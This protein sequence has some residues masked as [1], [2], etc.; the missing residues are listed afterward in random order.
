[1]TV[2]VLFEEVF[3][4]RGWAI[5]DADHPDILHGL[6]KQILDTVRDISGGKNTAGEMDSLRLSM[7]NI[8]EDEINTI[9]L[10]PY[11]GASELL[12]QAFPSAVRNLSG[13]EIFL[14]RRAHM[15]LNLP[16]QPGGRKSDR[17]LPSLAHFDSM[18]GISP[19]TLSLWM[20]LHDLDDD[21]GV[22]IIDQEASMEILN[23]E[24]KEGRVLGGDVLAMTA[25]GMEKRVFARM[26]YGQAVVFNP[27]CLHGSIPNE[28]K[29]ARICFNTRFQS[30]ALPLHL[31]TSDYFTRFDVPETV[32]TAGGTS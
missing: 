13:K 5:V 3:R 11:I 32:E 26:K 15:T 30:R 4:G 19:Y 16:A 8:P 24:R 2:N 10:Q 20:P 27:F 18:S 17:Y 23:A 31:R 28:T 12:A 7:H 9:K 25:P 14:Q 29:R 21:T 22:W 6:N 1:M